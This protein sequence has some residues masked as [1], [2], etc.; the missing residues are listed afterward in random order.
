M[1]RITDLWHMLVAVPLARRTV[2]LLLAG[3]LGMVVEQVALLGVLPPE[4]V[5]ALR[6]ALYAL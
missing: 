1:N 3:L 2:A 6:H 4:V 5:A